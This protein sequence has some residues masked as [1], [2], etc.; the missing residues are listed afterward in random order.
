MLSAAI[1]TA[2]CIRRLAEK[3][4][5]IGTTQPVETAQISQNSIAKSLE[6]QAKQLTIDP[7]QALDDLKPLKDMIGNAN[8]VGLGEATHG[9]SEIF[10][11]M[12][13]LVKYLVTELGFTNFGIKKL[14]SKY[15]RRFL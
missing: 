12:H 2:G 3:S 7:K 9:S 10:M 14:I 1:L 6:L 4:D 11:L 13:L 5:L 8:Y 15:F